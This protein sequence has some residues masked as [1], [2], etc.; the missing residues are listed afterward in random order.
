MVGTLTGTIHPSQSGPES[1]ANEKALYTPQISSLTIKCSLVSYSRHLFC[2]VVRVLHFSRIYSQH[3]VNP[4]DR[5]FCLTY[6][7][8]G[9]IFN[10]DYV[11]KSKRKIIFNRYKKK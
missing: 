10:Y 5:D 6:Y 1:N 3:I 11:F 7:I 9:L 4:A 8:E 2:A